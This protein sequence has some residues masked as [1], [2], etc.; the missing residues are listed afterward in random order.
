VYQLLHYIGSLPQCSLAGSGRVKCL[1]MIQA[2]RQCFLTAIP[3]HCVIPFTRAGNLIVVKA[4]VDTT[5]GNFILDTARTQPGPE[6]YLF[7]D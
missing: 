2:L 7:R 1:A 4:K 3:L 5:E 6:H